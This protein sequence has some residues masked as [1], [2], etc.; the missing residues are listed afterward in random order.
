MKSKSLEF[1]WC[2]NDEHQ[3]GHE[4]VRKTQLASGLDVKAYLKKPVVL[5]PGQTTLIPTGWRVKMDPEY[6]LQVR[7]RSGLAL[8]YGVHVLNSPGTVDADYQG[9]VGVILHNAGQEQFV[10]V[11]CMAI[12]QL[13]LCPIERC[14]VTIVQT[15]NLFDE[16]T[17]RG[18][19]GFGSTGG[20]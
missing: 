19:G 1:Q 10:V 8:K 18:Q 3:Q 17:D 6:E 14:H 11:D 9:E 16:V 4:P 12:A 2:G 15:G 13:V 7:S 20:F 5:K